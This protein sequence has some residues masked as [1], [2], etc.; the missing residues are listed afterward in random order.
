MPAEAAHAVPHV[1]ATA[2]FGERRAL[3]FKD[4][5]GVSAPDLQIRNHGLSHILRKREDALSIG[6]RATDFQTPAAP[7][8]ICE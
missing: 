6:L 5:C 4:V 1:I 7:I 8:D 2:L 3:R